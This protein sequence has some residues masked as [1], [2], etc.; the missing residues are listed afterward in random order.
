MALAAVVVSGVAMASVA[1]LGLRGAVHEGSTA[2]DQ[3]SM[4][5]DLSAQSDVRS[6]GMAMESE[7]TDEGRY[8]AVAGA[9]A[10]SVVIGS[11]R[12]R[13]S[14]GVSVRVVTTAD[15]TN[16][17]VVAHAENASQDWIYLSAGGLQA[18]GMVACPSNIAWR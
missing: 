1:V 8:P 10:E 17:C 15:R 5:Q 13:L 9:A 3:R 16:Y 6:V 2:L 7:R 11:E 12:V 14:P 4:A 18:P